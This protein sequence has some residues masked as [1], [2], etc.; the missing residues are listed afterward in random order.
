MVKLYGAVF[1][2][3]PRDP[4]LSEAPAH[5]PTA[6]MAPLALLAGACL[7]LALAAPLVTPWLAEVVAV[8]APGTATAALATVPIAT[9]AAALAALLAAV[10]LALL[11][12]RA[13]ARRRAARITADATWGCG[14]AG[15]SPRVQYTASS[16]S[17]GVAELFGGLILPRPAPVR[18]DG[19][20]PAPGAFAAP[21]PDP[22][23]ARVVLPIFAL[24]GRVLP[25]V[26][27]LQQGRLH[28]YL[29]YILVTTLVL[30][31]VD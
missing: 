12:A 3:T 2:G 11:A 24:F 17:A 18:C 28:V 20:L 5:E 6:M 14:Y 26:R 9:V 30:M 21:T 27:R 1:L 7:A 23:L 22:V 10:A 16:V 4:A 8:V 25:Q 31:L 19:V 29:L 13:L 15:A